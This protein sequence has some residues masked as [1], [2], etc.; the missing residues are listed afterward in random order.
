MWNF[1]VL[2]TLCEIWVERKART[3][4]FDLKFAVELNACH[5]CSTKFAVMPLLIKNKRCML[6]TK[7]NCRPVTFFMLKRGNKQSSSFFPY[8][9]FVCLLVNFSFCCSQGTAPE[10]AY[11]LSAFAGSGWF[12]LFYFKICII[13]L[14]YSCL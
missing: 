10:E 8:V 12:F 7:A 4:P 9:L 6:P 14:P 13:N 1:A 2:P 3:L 5:V 11:M